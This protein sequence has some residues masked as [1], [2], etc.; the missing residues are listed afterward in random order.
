MPSRRMGL[1]ISMVVLI[2]GIAY[3]IYI[4]QGGGQGGAPKVLQATGPAVIEL[5]GR[6]Y[7]ERCAACHG[8]NLEG[9]PGFDWRDKKPDG[10]FPAPPHDATGHTWHHP[11]TFLFAYTANGGQ[12]FLGDNGVS[13]MPAFADVLT[14]QEIEAVLVYIKSSWPEPIRERQR[15]VTEMQREQ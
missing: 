8:V 6:V 2:L 13:G 14:F 1:T 9:E 11:D 15:L 3:V 5:G 7:A 4:I 10:T 12:V